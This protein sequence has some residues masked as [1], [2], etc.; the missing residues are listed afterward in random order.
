M[1]FGY[2]CFVSS[3]AVFVSEREVKI[4]KSQ[5]VQFFDNIST[6]DLFKAIGLPIKNETDSG[7][8]THVFE[9]DLSN[10]KAIEKAMGISKL[11]CFPV[12]WV[13]SVPS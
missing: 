2:T 7:D 8:G 6:I 12:L 9:I 3:F 10:H 11:D 13:Y 4:Q 1:G 5:V